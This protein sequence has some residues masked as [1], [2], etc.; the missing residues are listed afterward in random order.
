MSSHEVPRGMSFMRY[1]Q[2]CIAS[3]VMEEKVEGRKVNS[4][5]TDSKWLVFDVIGRGKYDTHL[6]ELGLDLVVLMG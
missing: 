2:A 3:S 5:K 4:T 6:E 1:A